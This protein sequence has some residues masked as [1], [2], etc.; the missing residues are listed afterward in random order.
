LIP[1]GI[2]EG[3]RK[4]AVGIAGQRWSAVI[5]PRERV[6]R[7]SGFTL[8]ELLVMVVLIAFGGF[9]L[10]P[11]LARTSP[12]G[13][14]WQCLNNLQ[15]LQRAHA[16]YAADNSG[17]LAPNMGGFAADSSRWATGW[18]DWG[19][20]LANTNVQYL[21]N[22]LL[23]PYA[24]RSVSVYKCP[25]DRIPAL[26][27]ARVRSYSM[28]GFVGGTIEQG[29]YGYT[30][31]RVFTK[32]S[33]FTTPG[34][35]K[36]F[37]FI[38]EHPDSINDEVLGMRMG[39]AT[40]WPAAASWDDVPASSHNGAVVLSFADGHVEIHK[41][42]DAITM[43]PVKKTAGCSASGLTSPNDNRWLSSHASAPK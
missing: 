3:M 29:I 39:P 24:A 13:K 34:P 35:A 38:E 30:D 41:W 16:M 8:V 26:N 18:L 42:L 28:S 12:S 27:G 19:T 2:S 36:T 14:V 11:A 7:R 32:D 40:S 15:Q 23:G 25:A 33:D 9:L 37:V 43:V 21:L 31:Y 5:R 4:I 1:E 20:S 22:G 17:R 6:S 10:V